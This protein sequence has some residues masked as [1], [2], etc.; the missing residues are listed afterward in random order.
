LLGR[1]FSEVLLKN[2][3][4]LRSWIHPQIFMLLIQP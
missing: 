3:S 2:P 1:P 4:A